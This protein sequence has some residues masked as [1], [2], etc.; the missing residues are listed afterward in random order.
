MEIECGIETVIAAG[1]GGCAE[2]TT[3]GIACGATG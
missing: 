3:A 1:G 2:E